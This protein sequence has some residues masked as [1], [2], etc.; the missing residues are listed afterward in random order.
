MCEVYRIEGVGS[1]VSYI[2]DKLLPI[3][4]RE[5][6]NKLLGKRVCHGHARHRS[7]QGAHG[8]CVG[9]K[10]VYIG[11]YADLNG[12]SEV[13][14]LRVRQQNLRITS[15]SKNDSMHTELA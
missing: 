8:R 7:L 3:I 2:T 13:R 4:I 5:W 1:R 6:K 12:E 14:G 9:S 11:T 10:A 15:Q